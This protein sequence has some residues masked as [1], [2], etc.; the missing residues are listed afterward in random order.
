MAQSTAAQRI[1]ISTFGSFGDLHPYIAIALELK[2][3]GHRPVIATTNNYREKTDAL[4]LELHP[5]RPV[6]PSHDEPEKLGRMIEDFMD[7]QK[8]SERIF[9]WLMPHLRD[10]YDDLLVAARDADLLLTHPLPFVGPI[11]AEQTGVRW[12]SSVLAPMSFFSAY[13]PVV[14]P[15]A[16]GLYNLLKLSPVIGRAFGK[17]VRWRVKSMMEP[18]QALRAGLGMPRGKNALFEGQHSPALVLALFSSALGKPQPDWPPNTRVTGFCF[19]DGRDRAGDAPGLAPEISTFL[20]AGPP[21]IIFTLGSS[22]YW[23]A[24]DFY[25]ASA[26][27]A[28]ALGARALLLVG[29]ERFR[30]AG[31]LPAGVAAFEYAPFGELL[32]RGRL[33]V[34]HGGVGSTGNA[35]R[36]GRPALVV[37]FSHD[38]F[39]NGARVERGGYGRMLPHAKYNAESATRV[40]GELL[41][42]PVY[43]EKAAEA[44]RVI[45]AEDGTGVACDLIEEALGR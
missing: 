40:L 6:L 18:V 13:D 17:L 3:R 33:T 5:V 38:Q 39:D 2:R 44:G 7:T 26:Q 14:P 27:A 10:A 28:H 16:P 31:A 25:S 43:A 41:E 30:P 29:D 32:P 8:G 23:V 15:Q 1:V 22:A 45:R 11:V 9:K 42:N 20:D 37:P 12:V 35:L 4:G 34:F 21:P 24:K 36:A 19:Y